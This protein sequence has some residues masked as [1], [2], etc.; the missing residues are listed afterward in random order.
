[1]EPFSVV[2]HEDFLN[3][4]TR[5]APTKTPLTR[6]ALMERIAARSDKTKQRL[7]DELGRAEHIAITADCWKSFN[8]AFLGVTALWLDSLTLV[9]KTAALCC[10]RER[11]SMTYEKIAEELEEV[12]L[13]YKVHS[14]VVKVITDNG[15]NFLKAF[16][17]YDQ[18]DEESE[19]LDIVDLASVLENVQPFRFP[20]HQRCAAHTLNLVASVDAQRADHDKDYRTL[21]QSVFGKCQSLWTKQ[22][23]STLV[24][25]E[26]H[27]LCG[28][29]LVVPNATRWNSR[30]DAMRCLQGILEEKPQKLEELCLRLKLP[31]LRRP[32][33]AD[34]ISE[35]CE[36]MKPI[37][38]ALDILQADDKMYLGY[39]L[40]TITATRRRLAALFG[41][42]YCRPLKSAITDGIEKRFAGAMDD[43]ALVI[44]AALIPRFKLQWVPEADR[45]RVIQLLKTEVSRLPRREHHVTSDPPATGEPEDF[46]SF[47]EEGHCRRDSEAQDVMLYLQ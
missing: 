46:F 9:R 1:M 28:R 12:F 2:E 5:L 6:R 16:R 27:D 11:G 40:P 34:F 4:V 25:D 10:R 35:Y 22:N 42:Q 43:T 31:I 29:Y 38:N 36:V 8:R 15:S 24:A 39:L 47:N 33:E 30:Y 19:K 3:M 45:D 13:D 26:I 23:Q 44:S 41:L 21:S 32:I 7:L 20:P 14:K 17:V 37:A 18:H